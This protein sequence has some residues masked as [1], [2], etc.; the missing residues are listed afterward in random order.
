MVD[1][2]EKVKPE[3]DAPTLTVVDVH[4]EEKIL[5]FHTVQE[6]SGCVGNQVENNYGKQTF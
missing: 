6:E 1:A 3:G 2:E 5:V 4:D